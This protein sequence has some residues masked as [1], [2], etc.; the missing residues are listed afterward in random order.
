MRYHGPVGKSPDEVCQQAG[1]ALFRHHW[2]QRDRNRGLEVEKMEDGS[3][4]EIR[5]D[6]NPSDSDSLVRAIYNSRLDEVSGSLK[7]E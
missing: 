2:G 1:G 5:L 7:T 6:A 4:T 3:V